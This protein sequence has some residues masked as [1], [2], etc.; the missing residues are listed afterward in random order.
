MLG[1]SI[2]MI[3]TIHYSW[4]F[5]LLQPNSWMLKPHLFDIVGVAS[6][7]LCILGDLRNRRI[8]RHFASCYHRMFKQ[9][10]INAPLELYGCH[11]FW[12][13]QYKT[14]IA[15]QPLACKWYMIAKHLY[16]LQKHMYI[17]ILILRYLI[18]RSKNWEAEKV[19]LQ[20]FCNFWEAT[21]SFQST[22][23]FQHCSCNGIA[24]NTPKFFYNV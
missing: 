2:M 1:A 18:I 22:A 11:V 23:C 12:Q 13:S 16:T 8:C 19:P 20:R 24:P 14:W 9:N 7:E 15:L 6:C 4:Y 5:N 21:Q 10:W 17:F 3:L